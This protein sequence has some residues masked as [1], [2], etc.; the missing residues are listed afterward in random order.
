[1]CMSRMISVV[2]MALIILSP[3]FKH[4]LPKNGLIVQTGGVV[5]T[6][7]AYVVDFDS[8]TI[9]F[10][11][12]DWNKDPEMRKLA[13]SRKLDPK[14]ISDIRALADQAIAANYVSPEGSDVDF[15]ESLE[16][17]K[18]GK[19]TVT[20]TFGPVVDEKQ[21]ISSLLNLLSEQFH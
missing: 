16:V 9:R 17:S 1:M 18:H 10:Y 6:W 20:N 15:S 7:T 5:S 21:P 12:A 11:K 19:I 2:F 3:S 8:G 13:G 4:K 14:I